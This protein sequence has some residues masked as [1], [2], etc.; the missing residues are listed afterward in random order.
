MGHWIDLIETKPQ[1]WGYRKSFK[2]MD[3]RQS[4]EAILSF[5]YSLAVSEALARFM[6][7]LAAKTAPIS[8]NESF[9]AMP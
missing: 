2:Q 1:V 8:N 7:R 5:N 3:G 6:T 4:N 9:P